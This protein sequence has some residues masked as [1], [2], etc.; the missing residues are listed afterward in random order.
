MLAQK[1]GAAVQPT[2]PRYGNI[3]KLK[4]TTGHA[5]RSSENI[6]ENLAVL[7]LYLQTP[8]SR[9]R[10]RKSWNI[11]ELKLRWYVAL[12]QTEETA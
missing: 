6:R 9:G 10:R 11:F 12:K 8:M 7:L 4:N 1:A 5:T 3:S 2:T